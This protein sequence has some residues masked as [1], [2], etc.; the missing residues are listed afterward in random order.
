MLFIDNVDQVDISLGAVL[1][2]CFE[3]SNRNES[4]F[5]VQYALQRDER[6][7]RANAQVAKLKQENEELSEVFDD[8][9]H[10]KC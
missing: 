6:S 1:V 4:F 8:L 10:C 3:S 9:S 5:Y 7:D 2:A